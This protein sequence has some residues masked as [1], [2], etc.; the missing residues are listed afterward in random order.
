MKTWWNWNHCSSLNKESKISWSFSE[1]LAHRLRPYL[2]KSQPI[3][4]QKVVDNKY[5]VELVVVVEEIELVGYLLYKCLLIE[6]NVIFF[7][8][9][10][11]T[12]EKCPVESVDRLLVEM[13]EML[14]MYLERVIYVSD[15]RMEL[16]EKVLDEKM[17]KILIDV[18]VL[19]VFEHTLFDII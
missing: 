5:D 2:Q 8:V 6:I 19:P 3:L 18:E 10:F 7:R 15:D 16:M 17:M 1:I 12:Y 13:D 11:F 9:F 4:I 14:L